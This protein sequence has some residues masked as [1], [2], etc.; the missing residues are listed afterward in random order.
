MLDASKIKKDFPVW[1]EHPKLAYLDSSATSQTPSSIIRAM[2][3]YYAKYRANTRRGQYALS[4]RADEAFEHAR[5]EAANFL[6]A[7]SREIIFTSGA[8]AA[9]NMLLGM[10]E[11][12]GYFKEGDEIITTVM[13]HHS[14]LLPI[15]RLAK[16]RGLAVRCIPMTGDFE[17]DYEEAEKLAGERTK[18]IAFASVSNVTGTIHEAKRLSLLAREVGALSIAD[19][20]QAVSHIP[21]DVRELGCDFLFFSGHKMC[22]PTGIGILYGREELLK[23]FEP[24]FYGGGMVEDV[25]LEGD[26][27]WAEAPWK[28]EAGTPN[29]AGAIGLGAA[30]EYLSRIGIENIEAHIRELTSYA[31]QK[32]SGISG[33]KLFCEKNAEKN[34]GV[35]S[36]SLSGTHP[37]DV[38]EILSRG[39]IAV[40]AGHHCALPLIKTF[41]VPALIRVS[42]YLYNT[43]EDIDVLASG[44]E[45]AKQILAG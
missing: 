40:R 29:I 34:A 25:V 28:F 8:T 39:D 17:L 15:E 14:L 16:R 26:S 38:A 20:S 9:M 10:L 43:R 44:I 13:E 41:E 27:Q 37:H 33:V 30:C 22:G 31:L 12:S 4:A 11:N 6:G 19:A 45:E 1:S 21:V 3:E 24:G 32:L 5:G 2:D 18:L 23:K 35:I 42:I 36:F 7:N